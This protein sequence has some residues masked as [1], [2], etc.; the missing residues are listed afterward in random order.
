MTDKTVK[1]GYLKQ[2]TNSTV[3][4]VSSRE[5]PEICISKRR[6]NNNTANDRCIYCIIPL[7]LGTPIPAAALSKAWVCGRLLAGIAGSNPPGVL[8]VSYEC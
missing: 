3:T 7:V 6:A 1:K 8:N 5:A 4:T 2:L